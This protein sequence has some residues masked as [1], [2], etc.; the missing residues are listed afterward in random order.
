MVLSASHREFQRSRERMPRLCTKYDMIGL[1]SSEEIFERGQKCSDTAKIPQTVQIPDR[2]NGKRI[3]RRDLR[4]RVCIRKIPATTSN[5]LATQR[6]K[7]TSISPSKWMLTIELVRDTR[8]AR[9]HDRS[10]GKRHRIQLRYPSFEN[11]RSS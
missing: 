3:P 1:F 7:N 5:F 10:V 4:S 11:R 9:P 8:S 6:T 2:R